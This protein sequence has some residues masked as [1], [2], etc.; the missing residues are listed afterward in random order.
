MLYK[1]FKLYEQIKSQINLLFKSTE[2]NL[3]PMV[4]NRKL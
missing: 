3:E 4:S 2:I 1:I